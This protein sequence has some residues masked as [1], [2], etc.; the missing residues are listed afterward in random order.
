MDV[1]LDLETLDTSPTA[2][3]LS[4]GAVAFNWTGVTSERFYIV[5]D[6]AS[7]R[8]AG[9]SESQATVD[10]WARQGEA[11]QKV[12]DEDNVPLADALDSFSRWI[13]SLGGIKSIKMWGNGSDFDNVILTN[14]FNAVN[15]KLPWMFYNNRCYRTA[16]DLFLRGGLLPLPESNAVQMIG[17]MMRLGTHHHALDDAV[18]QATNLI[19][20]RSQYNQHLQAAMLQIANSG[21]RE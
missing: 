2:S 10:W 11:A 3:I 18:F 20:L 12:F 15:I 6:R 19:S 1:M 21:N 7:C 5:I 4:I 14:A 17:D 13:Q 8:E 16:R 9:L